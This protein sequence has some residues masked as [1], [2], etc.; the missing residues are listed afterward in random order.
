MNVKT[1][2]LSLLM[3]VI[4][5]MGLI[6]ATA[7]SVA[8]EADEYFGGTGTNIVNGDVIGGTGTNTVNADTIDTAVDYCK[9]LGIS[10]ATAEKFG[11]T[12]RD[13]LRQY[14]FDI[15]LTTLN[16]KVPSYDNA[17]INAIFINSDGWTLTIPK[18]N[19]RCAPMAS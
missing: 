15:D 9:I 10:Q 8:A 6:P 19:Q 18:F 5:L 17:K 2:I 12:I 11:T 3:A 13:S 14:D 1:R 16:I 7:V 4:L